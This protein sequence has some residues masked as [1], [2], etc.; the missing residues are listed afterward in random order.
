[1]AIESS[2]GDPRFPKVRL[3]ELKDIDIEISVLSPLEKVKSA[4]DIVLGEN[5]GS[6]FAGDST[7]AYSCRRW[8]MKPGGARW[9]FVY[10]CGHKAGLPA[11]AWKD[12]GTEL[13]VFTAE[14]FSE[15][16]Y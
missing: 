6:W 10:L 14:V 2:T 16:E 4:E 12:K 5:T 1:M 3:E 9:I 8:R 15:K 13:F 7:A 11:D